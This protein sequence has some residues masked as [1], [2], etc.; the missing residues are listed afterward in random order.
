MNENNEELEQELEAENLEPEDLQEQE[1]E[2]LEPENLEADKLKELEQELAAARA[3][4]YNYRQ[5]VAK[6]KQEMRKR[7]QDDVV[8]ALLPLLDNLDRALM[9]PE[10]DGSRNVLIGV[11]MV[12][13]QFLMSLNELGVSVI[14]TEHE[15]F[16]HNLHEAAGTVEV[17]AEELD[18][19]IMA[20]QLKGY[21]SGDKVLR[22]ARVLVGKFVEE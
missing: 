14:K 20:E 15:K 1:P 8:I 5:R 10:D 11:R 9:T 3:D 4:F 13:Q 22:A 6:E 19:V 2:V 18:G 21:K 12:Q 16:D 7:I 17:E